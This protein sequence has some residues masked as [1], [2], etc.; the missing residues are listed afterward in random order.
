[1]SKIKDVSHTK[2]KQQDNLDKRYVKDG[3]E[4]IKLFKKY[5]EEKGFT[6]IQKLSN[7]GVV[8]KLKKHNLLTIVGFTNFLGD[9]LDKPFLNNKYWYELHDDFNTAKSR[10]ENEIEEHW[11]TGSVNGDMN[12]AFSM[13]YGK[14]KFGY[15]DKQEI[16]QTTKL[17]A[18]LEV[19]KMTEKELK[20]IIKG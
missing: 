18:T 11:T 12:S 2:K 19:N 14:N 8:V 10:I 5:K 4:L 17:D 7:A 20:D 16:D 1:M 15:V 3:T 13:F 6:H 9:E